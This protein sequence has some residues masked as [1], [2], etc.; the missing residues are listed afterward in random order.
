MGEGGGRILL[1]DNAGVVV[2]MLRL[3]SLQCIGVWVSTGLAY[4]GVSI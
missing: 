3:I 2:V 1:G 4:L